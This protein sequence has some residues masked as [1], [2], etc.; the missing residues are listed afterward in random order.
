MWAQ[1]HGTFP[2]CAHPPSTPR[3]PHTMGEL[4]SL[5]QELLDSPGPPQWGVELLLEQEDAEGRHKDGG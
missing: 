1:A 2:L 5:A 4:Q 3:D